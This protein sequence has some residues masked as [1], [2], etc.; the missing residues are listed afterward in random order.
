MA[1]RFGLL[2]L[3]NVFI[4]LLYFRI[5]IV[6]KEP[7]VPC[8][9]IFGDS[10]VDSGNNNQL[11]TNWK[12]NYPPYGIDFPE[13]DTGR[14]TNGRTSAD[15]I[16]EF[17]GF[18]KFIPPYATAK[19]AQFNKGINYASGGSG[20][21][22]ETGSHMGDRISLD[23][24]LRRHSS[25]VSRLFHLQENITSLKKCIYLINIGSNDYINNY[26]VPDK[27]RTSRKYTVDQY[28]NVLIRKYSRQLKRLYKLGG[29][30][31]ALFGLTQIGCTPLEVKK[32]GS[33]GKPCVESINDAVNLFNDRLKP[34]V[35]DLN[36]DNPDARFTF[37]NITSIL[38]PQGEV[39]LRVGPC[40]K[41]KDDWACIPN[42]NPC[43]I[44]SLS[45]FFDALHP[46]ELSNIAI[47]TR[48][49]NALVPTDTYPY[50][51]QHLTQL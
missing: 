1:P 15:I 38:Y 31:V 40:C 47:A 49:Y 24:Q 7:E 16:G 27:Y 45:T 12:V 39:S 10:M 35:D 4:V 20:I 28:A 21:R 23:R 8:Y 19:D 33:N 5:I 44:R 6:S 36:N 9:F 48:S 14:F 11:L 18:D 32:F 46:T 37:I 17:L 3:V 30:K 43:S 50:D 51:I 2:A 41:L 42:S 34:L 29:R 26:L 13:G 22:E 25:I